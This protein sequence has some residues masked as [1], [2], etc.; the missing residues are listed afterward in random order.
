MKKTLLALCAVLGLGS[1]LAQTGSKESPLTVDQFLELGIP[2]TAVEDTY[3]KGY[4]VGY[5]DG[6]DIAK[7][8]VFG[9][10]GDNVSASNILL[11]SSSAEDDYN[12]C[13]PVQLVYNTELRADVNLK[14]NPTNLGREILI[15]GSRDKYFNVAGLKS[16]SYYKWL[17][18]SPSVDPAVTTLNEQFAAIPDTWTN[19]KVSG[20]KEFYATAYNG[21]TYAAATGYKGTQPPYDQWLISPA[22]DIEKCDSK[23]LTFQTQVNGYGSTTSVFEAYVLTS[24]DPTTAEKTKLNA[25]FATAPESGYSSWAE[26]GNIDL[27]SYK[28][29]IYVGFRYYATEDANYATWCVTNVKLNAS[30]VVEPEVKTY[31]VAEIIALG[32]DAK[33]PGQKVKGYI[34]GY[35]P[36][37]NKPADAVFS[38]EGAVQTNL[39]LADAANE[40]NYEKCIPV[41][42]PAGN[43]RNGLN[44]AD[45]PGNLGKEATLTG[46][47]EKYFNIP[48]FKSVSAYELGEGGGGDVPPV[49]EGVSYK[50]VAAIETGKPYAIATAGKVALNLAENYNYGYFKTADVA[51]GDSF[52]TAETVAFTFEDAGSG[53]YYIKDSYGRYIYMTKAFN[54]FNVATAVAEDEDSGFSW[55]VDFTADGVKI[56]NVLKG[57]TVQYDENYGSYG[58]Y[59]EVTHALP[60][61]FGQATSG[62]ENVEE[63]ADAPAEYFNLQGVRVANPEGGLY[64]VRQGKN[65]KKVMV[66]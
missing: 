49:V 4:I 13:I 27:S 55:T 7:G 56:V 19:L 26:S 59:A 3:V 45:N 43:V 15:C 17:S 42:L 5:V 16:P 10:L 57:K 53:A 54:S 39:L 60:S 66:K 23:I 6:G 40:T 18:D 46:N 22:I 52:S 21:Q 63:A 33:I 1:A 44:L 47:I 35:I 12:Y 2:G 62:V 50:K 48:G 24:A 58:A 20:D 25:N 51:E 8:S 14:D 34:V 28:G 64:I 32:A 9:K 31:S 38:A 29:K 30:E 36:G 41:Q 65:V 37:S 61:L 11:G